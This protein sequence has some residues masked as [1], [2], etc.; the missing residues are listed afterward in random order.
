MNQNIVNKIQEIHKNH[1]SLHELSKIIDKYLIPQENE[2]KTHAEVSTPFQLRQDMLNTIP[3][4]FWTTPRKV[5]EPCSGKGGFLIDIL[6]RF[7]MGLSDIIPNEKER[8]QTIVEQCLYFADIN[9]MNIFICRLLLDPYNEYKLN[10]Y[11]GNTLELDINEKWNLQGFDAVIGNPPYNNSQNHVGKRGGGDLLWNKFVCHALGFQYNK[12]WLKK[13][14]YLLYVH[15][16]G[17]RKPDSQHSK[18]KGLFRFMTH[19]NQMLYLEIHGTDDGLKSFGCGTRYDWYL[20]Q[21]K[22][23]NNPTTIVGQ[24]KKQVKL[25]LSEWKFLPNYNFEIMK[26]L[27]SDEY[28]VNIIYDS[29]SYE[30]RKQH[31]QKEKTSIF[32][33]PLIHTITKNNINYYY[34]SI[35]N[36]G[37]FGIPKVIFCDSGLNDIII[38]YEG[39]YGLTQHSIGIKICS[40]QEGEQIKKFLLHENFKDLIKSCSWSNYQIDWR[41]FTYFRKDFY[42]H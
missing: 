3:R 39:K 14:G 21:H 24:D 5:F 32:Q 16:S 9:P 12:H 22:T 33:Y 40:R 36:K 4:D 6:E 11:E 17:W 42:T 1:C 37:H 27:L 29:S 15:P 35:N 28:N 20:L 41:L 30:T 38:D 13:N 26:R 34:S 19:Q 31:V 2:K 10:Y 23:Y 25:N 8:Y 7:M 18:Y